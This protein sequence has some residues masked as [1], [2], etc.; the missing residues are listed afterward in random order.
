MDNELHIPTYQ[1]I[2][3]RPSSRGVSDTECGTSRSGRIVGGEV[4]YSGELPWTA[5][6]WRQKAHQCGATVLTKQWLMSAGHCVCSAFNEIYKAQQLSVVAGA[7]NILNPESQEL[8]SKILPHPDYR[9]NKRTN[10]V[11]L[12]RTV[13]ELTWSSSLKPACLPMATSDDFSGNVAT[14]AGWGFTDEDR[15]TGTRPNILH[16][17]EVMVVANDECNRWYQSQGSKI[18]II[19]TQMCAG[20]EDGGRDSCWADSG[21]PLMVK[22]TKGHSMVIGVVST[23]SGCAKARKPG[24]YTRVSRYVEWISESI[25]SDETRNAKNGLDWY[26]RR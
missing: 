10:D 26:P 14:V 21:G 22:N 25:N 6:V 5:S 3:V 20:Y 9:C 24:I 12:L 15:G 23:G 4:S 8:V 11:A 7:V 16:K 1:D 13:G 17:T 19:S 18:K 2:G